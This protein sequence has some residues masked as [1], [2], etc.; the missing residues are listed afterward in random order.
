M[1][2]KG[3]ERLSANNLFMQIIHSDS[4]SRDFAHLGKEKHQDHFLSTSVSACDK[5]VKV[6]HLYGE[7][8]SEETLIAFCIMVQTSVVITGCLHGR[9]LG[10]APFSLLTHD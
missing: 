10:P 1:F 6:R 7:Q 4:P 9:V 8:N 5:Y 3:F 2:L